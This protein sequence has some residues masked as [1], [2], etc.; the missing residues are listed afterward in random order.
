MSLHQLSSVSENVENEVG[1]GSASRSRRPTVDEVSSAKTV[2]EMRALT[3]RAGL[4]FDEDDT[5]AKLRKALINALVQASVQR[6]KAKSRKRRR[7]EME[8][9]EEESDDDQV[10]VLCFP[11]FRIILL[12]LKQLSLVHNRWTCCL[13]VIHNR[14]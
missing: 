2:E 3:T 4:E 7:K 12:L 1:L 10:C 14:W 9:S 11:F 8:A 13:L 5:I 6:S